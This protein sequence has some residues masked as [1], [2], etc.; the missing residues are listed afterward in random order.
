MENFQLHTPMGAWTST[1]HRSWEWF[2]DEETNRLKIKD[3]LNTDLS[4]PVGSARTRSGMH[5]V[6]VS[7]DQ[8]ERSGIPASVQ[9]LAETDIKLRCSGPPLALKPDDPS[10]FWDYLARQGGN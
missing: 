7:S 2:Y 6:K 9:T 4:H 10:D 8:E 5:Y 1:T 3:G